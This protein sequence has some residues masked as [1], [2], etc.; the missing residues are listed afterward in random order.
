MDI[1]KSRVDYLKAMVS[2][3]EK[4]RNTPAWMQKLLLEGLIVIEDSGRVVITD[5]GRKV[6][7]IEEPPSEPAKCP[8][9]IRSEEG[10]YV[11]HLNRE[12]PVIHHVPNGPVTIMLDPE[13]RE[14]VGYRV[15]MPNSPYQPPN[16]S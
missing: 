4:L 12:G 13:T 16:Q 10:R 5:L 7:G 3:G 9:Q 8:F 1:S 2:R 14:I 6:L 11:D 15:Y